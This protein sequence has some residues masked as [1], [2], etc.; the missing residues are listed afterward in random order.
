MLL[1][2][3][4]L[5]IPALAPLYHCFLHWDVVPLIIHMGHFFTI[6]ISAHFSH[7][8]R[9]REVLSDP[10]P[11]L[12]FSCPHHNISLLILSLPFNSTWYFPFHL[13]IVFLLSIR[14]QTPSVLFPDINPTP[15]T[16]LTNQ[17]FIK[18]F[19][20]LEVSC[21]RFFT[22]LK[23]KSTFGNVIF[24]DYVFFI[25]IMKFFS[26]FLF[27]VKFLPSKAL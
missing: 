11:K 13:F 22:I 3:V 23:G 24:P 14:A 1:H 10:N 15:K 19:S 9:G 4:I 21:T 8:Q 25:C 12:P 16:I 20:F 5:S 27:L 7:P 17:H 26:W 6:P 18:C 2:F